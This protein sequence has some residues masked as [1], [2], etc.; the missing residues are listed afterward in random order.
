MYDNNEER[1]NRI[2]EVLK[3][4]TIVKDSMEV[5]E[6]YGRKLYYLQEVTVSVRKRGGND[7]RAKV[8][9]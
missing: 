2:V 5:I 3:G 7:C 6:W 9:T 4:F 8:L 1:L